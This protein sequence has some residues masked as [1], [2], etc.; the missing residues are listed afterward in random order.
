[1][2]SKNLESIAIKKAGHT[3]KW[4]RSNSAPWFQNLRRLEDL[5]NIVIV[6]LLFFLP[7]LEIILRN[8]FGLPG[9]YGSESYSGH[10]LFILALS[11]GLFTQRHH[12]HLGL[13]IIN[14]HLPRLVQQI[15]GSIKLFW[16]TVILLL[17][18]MASWVFLQSFTGDELVGEI[19]LRL[20]LYWFPISIGLFIARLMLSGPYDSFEEAPLP[21]LLRI[22]LVSA[23]IALAWYLSQISILH[24]YI[25]DIDLPFA[26]QEI[27]FDK[28][29]EWF[30]RFAKIGP[31]FIGL[32]LLLFLFGFPIF[33][34]LGGISYMLFN[35]NFSQVELIPNAFYT[36]FTGEGNLNSLPLF[37]FA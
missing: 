36:L 32:T 30:S 34:T 3:W 23:G 7:L 8:F 5:L 13:S 4:L 2:F 27:L 29:H 33:L 37:A 16:A 21:F 9:L 12:M 28:E 15:L 22:F 14:I 25:N 6:C 26:E 31:W 1:M 20:I 10:L 19:P 18:G 11:A 24:Y 35:L 17:I